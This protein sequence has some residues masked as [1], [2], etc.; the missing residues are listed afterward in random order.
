MGRKKKSDAERRKKYG[1]SMAQETVT[2]IEKAAKAEKRSVSAM[3]EVLILEALA[4]RCKSG[5]K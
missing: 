1:L 2:S 5:K 3:A 4:G